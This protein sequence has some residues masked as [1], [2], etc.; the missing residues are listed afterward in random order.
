MFGFA[1][2]SAYEKQFMQTNKLLCIF[3]KLVK[4][5]YEKIIYEDIIYVSENSWI[6]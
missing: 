6:T 3:L 4:V 5:V 2:F 1:Y